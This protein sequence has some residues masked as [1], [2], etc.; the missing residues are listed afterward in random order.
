MAT[1]SSVATPQSATTARAT[2]N[3]QTAARRIA[4]RRASHE[5]HDGLG[6]ALVVHRL[7]FQT[8]RF[9][10]S[11]R[12]L[13]TWTTSAAASTSRWPEVPAVQ[14]AA[15]NDADRAQHRVRHRPRGASESACHTALCTTGGTASVRRR[16]AA[17]RVTGQTGGR[18]CRRRFPKPR[19]R[20]RCTTAGDN[21]AA[22]GRCIPP[23]ML[24]VLR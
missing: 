18:C 19:C 2:S 3:T 6:G 22:T 15:S 9:L 23:A 13:W 14:P 10:D 24:T 16:P 8:H 21:I 12:V 11:P 5:P 1:A 7:L 17:A 20:C 4:R